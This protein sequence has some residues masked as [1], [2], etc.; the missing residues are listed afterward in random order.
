MGGNITAI[1]N[2][3][4]SSN[5]SRKFDIDEDCR[6]FCT[7]VG[8]WAPVEVVLVEMT[9]IAARVDVRVRLE[10]IIRFWCEK[11]PRILWEDGANEALL[12]L[13]EEGV[14]R[15]DIAKGHS[16]QIHVVDAEKKFKDRFHPFSERSVDPLQSIPKF[17]TLLII[18]DIE[19]SGLADQ[20]LTG[21]VLLRLPSEVIAEQLYI[22]HLKY[23][24]AVDPA[25]DMSLL[26]DRSAS[27]RSRSPLVFSQQSPHFLTRLVY[28]HVLGLDGQDSANDV[29]MRAKFLTRWIDIGQ[30][31]KARGD[32]AGFLAIATALLSMPILR[33][34][35]TWTDVDSE[36]RSMVIRDWSPMMKELHRRELG[37]E[38]G[39]WTAHVLT[40][41]LKRE[42]LD[43]HHVIPYYGDICTA[44][45]AFDIWAVGSSRMILMIG[46]SGYRG[47]FCSG[48]R[49]IYSCGAC[50]NAVD[51]FQRR[52]RRCSR[53]SAEI[54]HEPKQGSPK[55][56]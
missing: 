4:L 21:N 1:C 43:S 11:T 45:E 27:H 56:F 42:E 2:H 23:L 38:V 32:L 48:E 28:T 29:L 24:S 39:T 25:D 51:Y 53:T 6:I 36:L 52:S 44:L 49:S 47:R 55:L 12:T 19:S 18:G 13:I 7:T 5:P 31:L 33:L 3:I 40:P 54:F 34:K 16:L 14:T 35:E 15:I 50:N 20:G 17:T 46:C 26:L 9:R 41:D 37:A 30:N 10:A 22:F 8:F